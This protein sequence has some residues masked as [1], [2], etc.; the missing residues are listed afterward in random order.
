MS[1]KIKL[2]Q[3]TPVLRIVS[4][5]RDREY[6]LFRW[7]RRKN[8]NKQKKEILQEKKEIRKLNKFLHIEEQCGVVLI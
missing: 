2:E 6:K 4:R 1:F 8:V 3:L 7:S 5:F